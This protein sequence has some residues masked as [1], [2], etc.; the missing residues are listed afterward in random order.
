M[1]G[2]GARVEAFEPYLAAVGIVDNLLRLEETESLHVAALDLPEIDLRV[3]RVAAVK[4][5]LK[6]HRAIDKSK[7]RVSMK[8]TKRFGS[9]ENILRVSEDS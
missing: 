8:R 9:L 6:Q 3:H 7:K 4:N 1:A 5:D 2:Q